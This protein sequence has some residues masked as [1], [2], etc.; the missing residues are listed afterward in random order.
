MSGGNKINARSALYLALKNANHEATEEQV[1]RTL[2]ALRANR[3]HLRFV[4]CT[5][6][7]Y[8]TDRHAKQHLR[9]ATKQG[10]TDYIG[11]HSYRCPDCGKWHLGH[12]RAVA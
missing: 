6:V 1:D 4:A 7:A 11:M 2:A 12:S 8:P 3:W 9:F 10:R 5:K